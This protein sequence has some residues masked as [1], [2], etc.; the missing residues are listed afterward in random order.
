MRNL[1][2]VRAK[3]IRVRMGILCGVM[4]VALGGVVA[5]A[6]RVQV[7]DGDA[8][9][10]TAEKQRQRR[11]H[12]EPKRGSIFDRKGAPLAVSVEVPSVSADVVEMLRGI[13]NDPAKVAFLKDASV[14][15]G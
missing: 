1:D 3:W 12:I 7:D 5:S 11:M 10:E 4:G 14:R 6:W 8:W 2:P 15:I 13:D 9:R